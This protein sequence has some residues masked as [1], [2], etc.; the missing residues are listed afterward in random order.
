VSEQIVL[1]PETITTEQLRNESNAEVLRIMAERMGWP[2]FLERMGT[3]TVDSW[4][5]PWTGLSYDLLD[6]KERKGNRQPRWLRMRS[7]LLKDGTT[8]DYIEKV[9]PELSSAQAARKWQ[10]QKADGSWPSVKECNA[11]KGLKFEMEA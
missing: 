10:F 2:L 6:L 4:L 1:L 3:V 9:H 8:P 5:D 11:K 7:P